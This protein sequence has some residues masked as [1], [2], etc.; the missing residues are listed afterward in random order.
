[1]SKVMKQTLWAVANIL[2]WSVLFGRSFG[3]GLSNIASEAEL[4]GYLIGSALLP[5]GIWLGGHVR[6]ARLANRG[7]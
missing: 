7:D 5:L 4:V 3:E 1:M 2:L 6:I